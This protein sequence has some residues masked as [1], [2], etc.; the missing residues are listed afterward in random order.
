MTIQFRNKEKWWKHAWIFRMLAC[1][2]WQSQLEYQLPPS[3]PVLC[4]GYESIMPLPILIS[5]LNMRS[6]DNYIPANYLANF[7][8]WTC[9]FWPTVALETYS[10]ST[11]DP[12]T[13][14]F[15]GVTIILLL[16]CV[17]TSQSDSLCWF[18]LELLIVWRVNI[19]LSD[20][21]FISNVVGESNIVQRDP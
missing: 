21:S 9:L 7:A 11:L 6:Q 10:A 5:M 14:D 2:S 3:N 16:F 20:P 4:L 8:I 13:A 18:M 15:I 12:S 17:Q 19:K 1:T